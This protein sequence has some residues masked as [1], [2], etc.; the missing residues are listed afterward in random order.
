LSEVENIADRVVF[1][2]KGRIIKEMT[3]SEIKEYTK[4]TTFRIIL[5][6]VDGDVVKIAEKYGNPRVEGNV[7]FIDNFNGN[8][9]GLSSDLSNYNIV[10][11]GKVE[12]NLEEVFFKLIGEQK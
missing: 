9:S 7:L 4:T 3:M 8:I 10:E 11:I 12:G 6:R 2:N 5:G 1:I